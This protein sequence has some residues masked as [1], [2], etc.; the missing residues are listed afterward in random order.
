VQKQGK[1]EL[2]GPASLLRC[3]SA[4]PFGTFGSAPRDRSASWSDATPHGFPRSGAVTRPRPLFSVA[5]LRRGSRLGR[6][7]TIGSGISGAKDPTGPASRYCGETARPWYSAS[8]F[9]S[10]FSRPWHWTTSGLPYPYERFDYFPGS[11]DFSADPFHNRPTRNLRIQQHA[12]SASAP[13]CLS[14]ISTEVRESPSIPTPLP[15]R[16]A[17]CRRVAGAPRTR[18]FGVS[19]AV[20]LTRRDAYNGISCLRGL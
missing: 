20:F 13:R 7:G 17:H 15:G 3:R 14:P 9:P 11:S 10:A 5:L 1:A 2:W 19:A 16:T 6:A 8:T 12:G 4:R 18:R